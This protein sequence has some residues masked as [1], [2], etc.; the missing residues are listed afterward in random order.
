MTFKIF[1]EAHLICIFYHTIIIFAPYCFTY[2]HELINYFYAY[3][4]VFEIVYIS[5]K[6]TLLK[7]KKIYI[8][9]L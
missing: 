4:F 2:I 6:L 1:Y 5:R 3:F 7:H 9:I 8:Y